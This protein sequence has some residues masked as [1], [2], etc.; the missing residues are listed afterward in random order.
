MDRKH[1]PLFVLIIAAVIAACCAGVIFCLQRGSAGDETAVEPIEVLQASESGRIQASGDYESAE[2]ADP[3][4]SFPDREA[5]VPAGYVL[6]GRVID[7][8]SGEPV[9][10]FHIELKK[11]DPNGIRA[12]GKKIFY[13]TVRDDR[14]RFQIPI[15]QEGTYYL[16]VGSSCYQSR[17]YLQLQVPDDG[18]LY[19]DELSDLLVKLDPGGSVSGR[20][21]ENAT[22]RAVTGALVGVSWNRGFGSTWKP[23]APLV[24]FREAVPC[25]ETDEEG[26]FTLKGLRSFDPEE[27]SSWRMVAAALHPDFAEGYAKAVPGT[28]E[29]IEIRLKRGFR[30][31]GKVLDDR[32]EPITGVMVIPEEEDIQLAR[33]A[34]SGPD[35]GYRTAPLLPGRVHVHAGPPPGETVESF[36]FTKEIKTVD[37][38]DNDV[39]VDFGLSD[40]YATWC[41][42][43]FDY[44]GKPVAG[45]RVEVQWVAPPCFSKS[46]HRFL[47]IAVCDSE[48]RFEKNKIIPGSYM[49][50]VSFPGLSN[51]LA[52]D[53]LNFGPG[54][55]EKDIH[56]S[57]AVIHGRVID[58]GTGE[59][60]VGT[61]CYITARCDIMAHHEIP[62]AKQYNGAYIDG[63]GNFCLRGLVPEFYSIEASSSGFQKWEKELIEVSENEVIKDFQIVLEPNGILSF[64]LEGF[65]DPALQKFN[66][67]LDDES[68]CRENKGLCNIGED[69]SFERSDFL[70][71]GT[72]TATLS[73]GGRFYVERRV[74]VLPNETTNL[75]IRPTD[76]SPSEGEITLMGSLNN[77]DGTPAV[78]MNIYFSSHV[79][80]GSESEK[81]LEVVTDPDGC[82]VLKGFKPGSWCINLESEYGIYLPDL[83]IPAGTGSPYRVDLVL[84]G[85]EVRGRL[86]DE[87]TGRVPRGVKESSGD[88][89]NDEDGDEEFLAGVYLLGQTARDTFCTNSNDCRF[90]LRLIPPGRYRVRVD[91]SE[92][93]FEY[94]YMPFDLTAG[95][96]LDLGALPLK[97]AGVLILD[98]VDRSAESIDKEIYISCNNTVLFKVSGCGFS[99]EKGLSRFE[100]LPLGRSSI[101]VMAEG[102]QSREIVVHLEPG[103]AEQVKVVL[104][105]K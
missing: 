59:P 29:E 33:P 18:E 73:F 72:W 52:W 82:F 103:Q 27:Y 23:W 85:G 31:F 96:I 25:A 41:G 62:Y 6:A 45:G 88:G 102:Y 69:G 1:K 75:V 74:R 19:D 9:R 105:L 43:L 48:G 63:K 64:S 91:P 104:D 70:K 90:R 92:G 58:G 53:Y 98:V 21:V 13:D 100:E 32:G 76:L 68:G 65:T 39:E 35:G 60:L 101:T 8:V 67:C 46:P 89:A 61:S 10:S 81:A 79:V 84:P 50:F 36:G 12:L 93:Y 49:V 71:P 40:E 15:T 87:L 11:N 83:I 30:L 17:S 51:R 80:P 28:G 2:V 56:I 42:T 14:G 38:I 3:S 34:F 99:I 24:G 5:I 94:I 37:I 4:G 95:Q 44:D 55:M 97:P 86:V 22:G 77:Y 20:V 16:Y 54:L 66:L 57:G 26:M 47:G 78:G 7:K